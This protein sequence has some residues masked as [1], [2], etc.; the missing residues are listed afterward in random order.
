[1]SKFVLDCPVRVNAGLHFNFS[2]QHIRTQAQIVDEMAEVREEAVFS[3]RD[4]SESYATTLSDA[5]S[6]RGLV[7][8]IDPVAAGVP[9]NQHESRSNGDIHAKDD[10]GAL[11]VLKYSM[12]QNEL[13][14]MVQALYVALEMHE[15]RA[16]AG[17]KEAAQLKEKHE[18][19]KQEAQLEREQAR[20]QV[21]QYQHD[22]SWA[23]Q[24]LQQAQMQKVSAG[25][26]V[27]IE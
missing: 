16:D 11:V 24:Q 14:E 17:K 23:N 26:Y 20:K 13:R 8:A 5:S 21:Q 1:M 3:A 9:A 4:H 7:H 25:A 15:Q 6:L 19:W 27:N 12:A 2:Y 18:R 10:E 22:L